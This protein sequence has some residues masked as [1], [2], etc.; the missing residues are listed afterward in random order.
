MII[1]TQQFLSKLTKI[2]TY[3]RTTLT[4]QEEKHH[5]LEISLSRTERLVHLLYK[6]FRNSNQTYYQHRWRIII[7]CL[8][9]HHLMSKCS[10]QLLKVLA[11]TR[12]QANDR[13]QQ[14]PQAGVRERKGS[15][16]WYRHT[17][18]STFYSK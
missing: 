3:L 18:F 16:E 5:H 2:S 8:T 17:T 11:R 10:R 14:R 12:V 15:R 7:V 9:I 13:S 6:L 1:R 4:R